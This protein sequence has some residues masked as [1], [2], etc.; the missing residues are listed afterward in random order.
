MLKVDPRVI[1][2]ATFL[3]GFAL[4]QV[5]VFENKNEF[6]GKAEIASGRKKTIEFMAQYPY[7][8]G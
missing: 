6:E 7:N 8:D 2:I 1:D 4:G 3:L 5:K